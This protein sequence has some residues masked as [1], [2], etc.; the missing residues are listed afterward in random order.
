MRPVKPATEYR[1][2]YQYYFHSERG[3]A[4]LAEH[5]YDLAKL[6][7]KLWSPNWDFDEE[8]YAQSAT[9]FDNPDFIDVVIHSY[10]HRYDLVAGDPAYEEIEQRLAKQP[11]ITVPTVVLDG[12]D[13]GVMPEGSAKHHQHYFTNENYRYQGIPLVGHNLPQEAPTEFSQAIL[14]LLS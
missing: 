1:Y 6:L 8:T 9:S 4:G 2:W 11:K 10:R 7:W 12:E 13:N 5:R 14:S 3:R